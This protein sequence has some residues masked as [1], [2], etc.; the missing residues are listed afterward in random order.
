MKWVLYFIFIPLIL[1][2]IY[3]ASYSAI[4]GEVNFFNDVSR[5]FL[6]LRE[7]DQKKIVFIGPRSN[8]N[9]L[10]HGP[11]WTYINYPAYVIGGG[12]PVFQAWF[13]LFIELVFL[14]TSFY[15]A[16]KLFGTFS[17]LSFV[18]LLSVRL[19]PHINGVFHSEA[20]FFVMPVF[21][22]SAA[23]YFM[24]KKARFLSLHF[25]SLVFLVQL[26]IGD[27]IPFLLLSVPVVLWFIIKHKLWKHLLAF[28]IFPVGFINFI[29][30]DIK[31]N[32]QMAK[33]LLGTG[34][35]GKFFMSVPDWIWN[36]IDNTVSLELLERG[37]QTLHFIIFTSVILCSYLIIKK[38]K[39]LRPVYLLFIYFY[40]GYFAFTYFNKGVLLF[41]YIYLLIP[42]TYFWLTSFLGSK[43]KFIFVFFVAIVFV[44]NL[45]AARNYVTY[46][47]KDFMGKNPYSWVGLSSVANDVVK[48]QEGRE[49]GYFVFAPDSFAYQPRY[50]MIYNFKAGHVNAFE[51]VKKETTYV[52]AQGAP[53]NDPYMDYKWWVKAPVGITAKPTRVNGF[54]NGYTVLE[55]HL[56]P[57]EQKI[58][59]D[60]NIELG[61]HFR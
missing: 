28:L 61:I 2:N 32:F 34:G 31:H 54:P 16:K 33:A 45:E 27:G 24:S 39:K 19:V 49:F 6:L 30:F 47:Q 53:S 8:T 59:H 4:H 23:K 3:L 36:R 15:M 22:F 52:I 35:S 56:T 18:L 9:N 60:K 17:A 21:L 37:N 12:N 43:Y 41:H 26:N 25:V 5:D 40:F 14:A 44:M 38:S 11:L 55:Y 29:L 42:F 58:P 57:E 50:A 13:W 46:L 1:F 7:M 10:F 20:T 51:Y 48:R